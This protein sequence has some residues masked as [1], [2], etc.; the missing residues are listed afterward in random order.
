MPLTSGVDVSMPT[1]DILNIH[2]DT[3]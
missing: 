1:M 3:N 2:H